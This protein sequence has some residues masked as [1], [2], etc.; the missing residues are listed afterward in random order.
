MLLDASPLHRCHAVPSENH[1]PTLQ[2]QSDTCLCE[3]HNQCPRFQR[4]VPLGDVVKPPPRSKPRTQRT[5]MLLAGAATLL[6]L[7]AIAWLASSIVAARFETS[8]PTSTPSAI[9]GPQ[10]DGMVN[11]DAA[12]GA[13]G[14]NADDS[15][16]SAGD[17]NQAPAGAQASAQTPGAAGAATAAPESTTGT[18]APT[19]ETPAAGAGGTAAA[20]ATQAGGQ[21]QDEGSTPIATRGT[22]PVATLTPSPVPAAPTASRS[23]ICCRRRLPCLVR[24]FSSF[25]LP[26]ATSVGGSTKTRTAPR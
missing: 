26:P 13:A 20:G 22:T 15:A 10:G 4:A 3:A 17:E 24:S 6:V 8:A 12:G 9:A 7:A 21:G 19:S 2:Y 14:D 11:T 5:P 23:P 18:D 1:T 16:A 25:A